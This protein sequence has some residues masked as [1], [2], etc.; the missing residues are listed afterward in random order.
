MLRPGRPAV[1]PQRNSVIL[2]ATSQP[3]LQS[4]RQSMPNASGP[5]P[6]PS[7]MR[8]VKPQPP[9]GSPNGGGGGGGSG[10]PRQSML[11]NGAN[12]IS[13]SEERPPASKA[14]AVENGRGMMRRA[15]NGIHVQR[16]QHQ[17][18]QY[19]PHPQHPYAAATTGNN[20]T[21]RR[22]SSMSGV[23]PLMRRNTPS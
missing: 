18:E 22:P 16:Q 13:I 9:N 21:Q 5:P 11:P 14:T 8:P 10:I 19:Q 23:P 4:R 17:Q 12:R 3:I 2:N 6:A 15:D 7:G 20:V 1:P